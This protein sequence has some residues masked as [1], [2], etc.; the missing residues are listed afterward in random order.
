MK[1]ATG[2]LWTHPAQIRAITTNGYVKANGECVMGRGCAKEARDTFPGIAKRLGDLIRQHGNRCFL[3]VTTPLGNG[4]ASFPVKHTWSQ[5][6]DI[7]LIRKSC[8]EI[9][10][11]ADKFGWTDILLPRPGCGN[12]QLSWDDVRPVIEP[13][14]DD[15]F[16]VITF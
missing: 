14:L 15:R 4:I 2:N 13:L 1:E 3:L 7:E 8:G 10:A 5:P 11:M 9:S 6:A 12:G 16:T